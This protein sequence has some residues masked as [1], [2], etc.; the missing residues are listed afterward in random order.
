MHLYYVIVVTA[1]RAIRRNV[2]RSAL[3]CL[4]IIIAVAAVIAIVEIGNGSAAAI[5]KSISS[6]G[7]GIVLVLPGAATS[8][9]ISFG[10]GTSITLTPADCDYIIKED[11]MVRDVAPVVRSHG[12]VIYGNKNWTPQTVQGTTPSFLT[13]RDWDDVADG[14]AITDMDVRN[15]NKVCMIGQTLVKQL[16][17]GESPIGREVRL[18]NVS[19]KVIGVLSTK[20]GN[21][22]GQ[23]QD[24]ILIAPWTTVKY[25]INGSGGTS[26]SQGS[27]ASSSSSSSTPT[28]DATYSES[29]LAVYS[30][31][32]SVE[33]Q[34]NPSMTRFANIDQI[35][36][37][38][39][40]N[41]D[42]VPQIPEAIDEVTQTLHDHHHI[43]ADQ[44]DDFTIRDM[45]E[46]ANTLTSTSRLVALLL[47]LVAMISLV[48]GGVGIMNIMMVSVTE[49]T[50]EI[51]LRMAVGAKSRD[52]LTQFLIEAVVLCMIGGIIGLM[53]GR[54]CSIIVRAVMNWPT[55]FSIGAAIAALGVSASVGIIFGFYPAW[56]ASR[57]DP[58]EALRYE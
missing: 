51:G 18:Q 29:S 42:G 43:R 6:M 52:I 14:T 39:K 19:L 27:A 10:S 49:R 53:C 7:A 38:A 45:T 9:G 57:L 30:A 48:V 5:Q 33:A 58:I 23:D 26:G 28:S 13:L 12:Q 24:D 41:A 2:L 35:I 34:D 44:V 56:K 40:T 50:R 55:Q 32:S 3:T 8:A 22:M 1:L 4:G 21:M 15:A 54:I 46:I 11:P 17:N 47:L 37:G 36:V 16:F 31:P 20:G 25:R